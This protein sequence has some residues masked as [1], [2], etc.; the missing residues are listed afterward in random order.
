MQFFIRTVATDIRYPADWIT[1][2]LVVVGAPN[3]R[4][5]ALVNLDLVAGISDTGPP[6]AAIVYILVAGNRHRP[7]DVLTLRPEVPG[8]LVQM[9]LAKMTSM[10]LNHGGRGNGLI[11]QLTTARYTTACLRQFLKRLSIE[12]PISTRRSG[13]ATYRERVCIK[14]LRRKLFPTPTLE[15]ILRLFRQT[16]S[17]T[18]D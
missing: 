10:S 12:P 2:A 11:R 7:G 18:P 6:G 4:S 17:A 3:W 16:P 15:A 9:S 14:R 1:G 8:S 13:W 5:L